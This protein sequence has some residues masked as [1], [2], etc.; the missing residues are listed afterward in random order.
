MTLDHLDHLR[1]RAALRGAT[2]VGFLQGWNGPHLGSGARQFYTITTSLTTVELPEADAYEYGRT[3]VDDLAIDPVYR[4][5][6]D[7]RIHEEEA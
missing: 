1:I 7:L 2:A 5:N 6:D 4:K 3:L